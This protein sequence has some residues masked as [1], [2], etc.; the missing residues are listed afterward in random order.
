M[1]IFIIHLKYYEPKEERD[2]CMFK[3]LNKYYD[4][5]TSICSKEVELSVSNVYGVST[6]LPVVVLVVVPITKVTRIALV[7]PITM[8][9]GVPIIPIVIWV[10]SCSC[11]YQGKEK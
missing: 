6:K 8:V 9:T 10:V 4:I 2:I 11:S 5:L 1:L 7:P 3:N